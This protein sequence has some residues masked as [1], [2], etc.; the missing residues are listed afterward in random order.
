MV[1]AG[2]ASQPLDYKY[3]VK[4]I[5]LTVITGILGRVPTIKQVN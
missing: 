2:L 3:R 5:Q 4:E 1:V